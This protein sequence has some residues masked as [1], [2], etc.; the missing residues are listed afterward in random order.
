MIRKTRLLYIIAAFSMGAAADYKV[1]A[2]ESNESARYFS[3]E[4]PLTQREKKALKSAKEWINADQ[5]PYKKDGSVT[6][7]FD[8]GQPTLIC[9][10]L[11]LCMIK[12]ERGEQVVKGGIH[13]GDSARWKVAP[14]VGSGVNDRTNIVI[15]PV[16]VGL[17]TSMAIITDRR[18]YHI[19]LVSRR[20]DYMPVVSFH[21]PERIEAEW[22]SYYASK[23]QEKQRLVMPST[24]ESIENLDFDYAVEGCSGCPWRPLRVYNDGQQTIIQMGKDMNQAE[25]PALLVM[26]RDGEQ[27]VN[28]RISGDRYI[29]DQ[30][31][32]EAMMVIGVGWNQDRVNIR[33]LG[34]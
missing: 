8:G 29:V 17:E 11:Q 5:Y 20:K 9:A 24:G 4:K 25:A 23:A 16:E 14:A 12:L 15:K 34:S 1:P 28:Y 2:I 33:R 21:Y 22:Q 7:L 13:L 31:F 18:T 6:F 19:R 30:V 3:S 27:L 26:T 10:P 32:A